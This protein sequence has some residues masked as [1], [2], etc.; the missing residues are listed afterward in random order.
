MRAPGFALEREFDLVNAIGV[1]FHTVED[2]R[3]ERAVAGLA[4][5]QRGRARQ[6]RERIARFSGRPTRRARDGVLRTIE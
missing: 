6:R 3:W 4:G 5:E 1:M 2:G